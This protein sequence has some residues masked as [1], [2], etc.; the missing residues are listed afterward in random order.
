MK[1]WFAPGLIAVL[2]LAAAL[3]LPDL[4]LRPLHNDESVNTIKFQALWD[5]NAYKYDKS[6]F[7]GPTLPYFTLPVALLSGTHDFNEFDEATFRTVT[8]LFG[9]ALV[10]SILLLT[11]EF[12]R[13]ETFWAALFTALSPAMVFYSRYY[14]HEMLLVF[15]TALMAGALWRYKISGKF[16]WCALAGASAALMWAT[17]ETWVFAIASLALAMVCQ[18]VLQKSDGAGHF[19]VNFKHAAAALAI[20]LVVAVVFFSSFFTNAAGIGDAVKTYL[21]WLHR[22]EGAS[23]HIHSWTFYFERLLFYKANGGPV[24]SE[25]F[26]AVLAL[27]GFCGAVRGRQPLPCLIAFYTAWMTLIYTLLPYKTTWCLLGFWHGTILLAGLGAT[28]LARW[29]KGLLIFLAVGTAHLGWEAWRCN[30]AVDKGG[31]PYCDSPKNPYTYSQTT[32][33]IFRLV[34]TVEAVA[35]VG[36]D[37]YGTIV[38]VMSPQSS[39][40]LPW[41][42][43]RFKS[44]NIGYFDKIP[45][46]PLAPIMIVST[47]LHAAFDERPEHTHLMAGYYE[48]RPNVFFELYVSL[49]LWS[50]YV[51]TL[52]R[53]KD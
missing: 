23:P 4:G 16:A 28:A 1:R 30:F 27:I 44:T 13:A 36:P 19:K 33:D 38:E 49:D 6:E 47:D 52:P 37:G 7:H 43:R 8:A 53:G 26:I 50:H 39:W 29:R 9:I 10:V 45:A 11:P 3:R 31:V 35:K 14:I 46:Q 15:F 40:P 34:Q 18:A 48:L 25:A 42:L 12:G 17:K 20:A 51:K 21:P 32:P 41:Y 22:A 5:E 2:I 24:W